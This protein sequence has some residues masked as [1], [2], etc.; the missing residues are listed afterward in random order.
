[1]KIT[2]RVYRQSEVITF[3]NTKGE[4][5]G[6][7][8]MAPNFP[9][10]VNEVL[11]PNTEALYQ[12]CRFPL[13]PDIQQEIIE[14]TSPMTSKEISRKYIAQTR[15]D[16][17]DV[18][19][20]IMQWCLMVKLLQNRDSFGDLLKKTGDKAIVEYSIKDKVWAAVPTGNGTLVGKNALGRLLMAVRQKYIFDEVGL[21]Y[22]QPL[23]IPAFLLFNNKID[24]VYIPEYFFMDFD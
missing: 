21:D 2:E 22:I 10:F 9:V 19:F 14:Q 12:A 17:E 13:F 4:F 1:M 15:Q 24:K 7:S 18:K 16:W 8:N 5:G 11:I 20:D 23:P 6:L 3:S